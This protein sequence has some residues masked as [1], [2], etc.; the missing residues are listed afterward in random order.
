MEQNNKAEKW[1]GVERR[2]C[3]M[4]GAHEVLITDLSERLKN[5]EDL[6]PV[7]TMNFKWGISL[8]ISVMVSLFSISIYTTMSAT[9][10]LQDIQVK[11]ERLILQSEQIREDIKTVKAF[12]SHEMDK[13]EKQLEIR[14]DLLHQFI[15]RLENK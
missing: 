3:M 12:H 4:H 13:I 1:D 14:K 6:K 10:A 8:T 9:K 2:A 5:L 7:S 15:D 11:Q